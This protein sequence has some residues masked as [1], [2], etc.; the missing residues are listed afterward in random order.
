[1]EALLYVEQ[2]YYHE[3]ELDLSSIEM[4]QSE[5]EE[6]QLEDGIIAFGPDMTLS[7]I[8]KEIKKNSEYIEKDIISIYRGAGDK[9]VQMQLGGFE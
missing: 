7:N 5:G 4:R 6:S 1:M 9:E 3:V 8:Y 2:R